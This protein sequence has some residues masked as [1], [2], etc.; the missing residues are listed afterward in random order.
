M[1]VNVARLIYGTVVVGGL[2]ADEAPERETY[3]EVLA[4]VGI[5][6]LVY[7]SQL[8]TAAA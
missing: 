6:L 5:A 1:P 4:S 3:A 2:L 8:L 7:L